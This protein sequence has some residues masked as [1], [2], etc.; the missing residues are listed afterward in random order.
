MF[1]KK[2][3][4]LFK[5]SDPVETSNL[6]QLDKEKHFLNFFMSL[7]YSDQ[8]ICQDKKLCTVF[9]FQAE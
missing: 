9:Y 4:D 6:A 3:R 5:K 2:E 7:F 1:E 8:I